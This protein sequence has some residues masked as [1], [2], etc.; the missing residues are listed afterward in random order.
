MKTLQLCKGCELFLISY[1]IGSESKVLD[2]LLEL[3]RRADIDF[4]YFDA[5]LLSHQLGQEL[6]KEMMKYIPRKD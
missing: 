5:A 6:S 2:Y 1:E 3:V 4:D